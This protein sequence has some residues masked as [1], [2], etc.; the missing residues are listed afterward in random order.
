MS[1]VN[2]EVSLQRWLCHCKELF[3][4]RL[5][6][7]SPL[8]TIFVVQGVVCVVDTVPEVAQVGAGRRN[9]VFFLVVN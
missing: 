6:P 7:G 5:S 3:Y 1:D 4:K 9:R 2:V 8:M